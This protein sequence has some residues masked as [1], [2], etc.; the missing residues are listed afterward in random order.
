MV[1]KRK[2]YKMHYYMHLVKAEIN[3]ILS[4]LPY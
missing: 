3:I 1:N 2:F 4:L